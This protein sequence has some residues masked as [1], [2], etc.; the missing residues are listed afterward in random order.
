MSL[1]RADWWQED[2]G[3]IEALVNW[4]GWILEARLRSLPG[5][6]VTGQAQLQ[7]RLPVLLTSGL[8]EE[9]H[10]V[11]HATRPREQHLLVGIDRETRSRSDEQVCLGT[12]N[13]P[14]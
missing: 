9:L 12:L 2:L 7:E 6:A 13:G 11:D 1:R 4:A 8:V 5:S 3:A 10:L 14:V